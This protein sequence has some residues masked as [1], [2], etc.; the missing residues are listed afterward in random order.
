MPRAL[1]LRAQAGWLCRAAPRSCREGAATASHK[2]ALSS[3][4]NTPA[5]C[6]VQCNRAIAPGARLELAGAPCQHD[7]RTPP[8]RISFVVIGLPPSLCMSAARSGHAGA[9]DVVETRRWH[10]A[11]QHAITWWSLC[12]VMP[13][14]GSAR[15]CSPLEADTQRTKVAVRP[16]D[17]LAQAP[18]IIGRCLHDSEET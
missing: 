11:R 12:T 16:P 5:P 6:A 4:S 9:S 18:L 8:A 13:Y 15:A 1:G 10:R 14:I 2:S 3:I 17:W 7:R